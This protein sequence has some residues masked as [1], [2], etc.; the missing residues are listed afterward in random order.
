MYGTGEQM[1]DNLTYR[2]TISVHMYTNE[3]RYNGEAVKF[4]SLDKA[5][6]YAE[7]L[8]ATYGIPTREVGR[9]FNKPRKPPAKPPV[10]TR[11]NPDMFSQLLD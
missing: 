5:W 11:K 2:Y 9:W 7:T 3:V 4:D 1:A 6:D 8:Q 10:R